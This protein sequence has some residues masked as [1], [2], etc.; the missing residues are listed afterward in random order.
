MRYGVSLLKALANM[1]DILRTC[2]EIDKLE[3][4]GDR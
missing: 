1:Q 4:D 2:K 3:G